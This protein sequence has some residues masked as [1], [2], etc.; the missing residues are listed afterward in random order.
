MKGRVTVMLNRAFVLDKNRQPL[1]PCP[2]HRAK[3]LLGKGRGGSGRVESSRR[4]S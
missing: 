1:M 4:S 3:E 2:M